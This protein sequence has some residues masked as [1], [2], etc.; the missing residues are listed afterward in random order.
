MVPKYVPIVVGHFVSW[1]CAGLL[2]KRR[3][4]GDGA[5]KGDV[6]NSTEGTSNDEDK[7]SGWFSFSYSD[8]QSPVKGGGGK[9]EA[10]QQEASPSN[11]DA[12]MELMTVRSFEL[13]PHVVGKLQ[14]SAEDESADKDWRFLALPVSSE[15]LLLI[16]STMTIFLEQG[17][18]DSKRLPEGLARR[19]L[20]S[21]ASVMSPWRRSELSSNVPDTQDLKQFAVLTQSVLKLF[22]AA[23]LERRLS[24]PLSDTY[25]RIIVVLVRLL[26][27]VICLCDTH[28]DEDDHSED[29]RD[30][31]KSQLIACCET[32]RAALVDDH[33]SHSAV[34]GGMVEIGRDLL[35]VATAENPAS[36]D[37]IVICEDHC[38]VLLGI[39]CDMSKLSEN[40][41]STEFELDPAILM[42]AFA[43]LLLEPSEPEAAVPLHATHDQM[44][45]GDDRAHL[46]LLL[47]LVLESCNSKRAEVR[48]LGMS[49]MTHI[50]LLSF[51]HSFNS[52]RDRVCQLGKENK[53]L[54]EHVERLQASASLSY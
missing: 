7:P 44:D 19:V 27:R 13:V 39:K 38:R 36:D 50:D 43:I 20:I 2:S 33:P 51:L 26:L 46:L 34:V 31:F 1:Q 11:N 9:S 28:H 35:S 47:P 37:I 3:R 49:L 54:K 5:V 30:Y 53:E 8:N 23:I 48:K 52:M 24:R 41:D 17:S 10:A 29:E 21:L 22:G 42:D 14:I 4:G 15:E 32:L 40:I 18:K 12:D 25:V 6:D 45:S 16:T